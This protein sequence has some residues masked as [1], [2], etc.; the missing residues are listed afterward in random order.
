M[1]LN[2]F[3]LF[4]ASDSQTLIPNVGGNL[5]VGPAVGGY[6]AQFGS[7]GFFGT[8]NLT[9]DTSAIITASGPVAALPGDTYNFQCWFRDVDPSPT[10]NLT[11]ASR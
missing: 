2:Q 3:A 10:S 8:L 5:C 9:V 7:T 1:P 6:L 4:I 11:R